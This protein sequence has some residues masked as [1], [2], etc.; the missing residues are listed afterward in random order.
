MNMTAPLALFRRIG[1]ASLVALLPLAPVEAGSPPTAR[2]QLVMFQAPGCAWCRRWE[3]EIGGAY[4]RSWAG[5]LAPLRRVDMAAARPADLAGLE[6]IRFSPTF[7]LLHEGA[8]VGRIVGYPGEHFFWPLLED[9][10]ERVPEPET[11]AAK[12]D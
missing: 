4:A 12:E 11:T 8:E 7:V 9:L 5:R 6:G 10:L 3:A 2:A 1:A